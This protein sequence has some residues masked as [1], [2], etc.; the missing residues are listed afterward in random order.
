[1][2]DSNDPRFCKWRSKD[3]NK[4]GGTRPPGVSKFTCVI[5]VIFWRPGTL[6]QNTSG[7]LDYMVSPEPSF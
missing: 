7:N 1:M 6:G 4:K 2:V 5:P 3:G